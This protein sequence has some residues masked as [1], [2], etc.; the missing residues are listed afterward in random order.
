MP[1]AAA[2]HSWA[3]LLLLFPEAFAIAAA[4]PFN[5]TA[6]PVLLL[7]KAIPVAAAAS[8]HPRT[9][10]PFLVAV[11][12]FPAVAGAA[13]PLQITVVVAAASFPPHMMRSLILPLVFAAA[14]VPL[15]ATFLSFL[16]VQ[17]LAVA[18]MAAFPW[19]A[20]LSISRRLRRRSARQRARLRLPHT[21]GT[22]PP[23]RHR[24][25]VAFPAVTTASAAALLV[26]ATVVV[27]AVRAFEVFIIVLGR[28]FAPIVA[29]AL[30]VTARLRV[31]AAR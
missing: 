6:T 26:I 8:L 18:T 10:P 3:T 19:R 12:T 4:A 28:A 17:I 14:S 20:A 16:G 31:F 21:S 9:A 2:L 15:H 27:A 29:L 22:V 30:V 25:V 1:A 23:P 11:V 13:P 5:P 7:L 24:A